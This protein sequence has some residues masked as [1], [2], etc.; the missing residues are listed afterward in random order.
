MLGSSNS[1]LK[2]IKLA[3]VRLDMYCIGNVENKIVSAEVAK[4]SGDKRFALI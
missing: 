1:K 3:N 4:Q 2:L